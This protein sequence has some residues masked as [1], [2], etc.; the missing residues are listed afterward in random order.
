MGFFP[1]A[2][3]AAAPNSGIA[4]ARETYRA[5]ALAA[6]IANLRDVGAVLREEFVALL[7]G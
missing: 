7:D 2:A 3:F 4:F 6:R 5:Y 1:V